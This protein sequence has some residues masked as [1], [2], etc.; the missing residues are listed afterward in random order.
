ME[1]PFKENPLENAL[2]VFFKIVEVAH[3]LF[4]S[5][6]SPDA[7][8]ITSHTV[9]FATFTGKYRGRDIAYFFLGGLRMPNDSFHK[10]L[11]KTNVRGL[12]ELLGGGLIPGKSFFD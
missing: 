11:I 12:D 5:S 3:H 7:P 2:I 10:K 6:N 8:Q 9:Y 1:S 4:C